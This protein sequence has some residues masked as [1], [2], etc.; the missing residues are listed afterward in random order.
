MKQILFG[1][2]FMASLT[3]A[4]GSGLDLSLYYGSR[5]VGLGG[6]QVALGGDAYGPFYNPATMTSVEK[7]ALAID[8][9]TLLFQYDAPIGAANAQK[10]SEW[11]VGPLFY[12]GGVYHLMDRVSVGLAVFP[13]A[14]QGGKYTPVDYGSGAI[15]TLSG[16]EMSNL[17]ARIEIAPSVA[18][19]VC[20]HFSL[21][22]SY[23]IAYTRYD[24]AGG[25]FASVVGTQA[26]FIDTSLTGWDATGAKFGAFVDHWNN[27]SAGITYRLETQ[28]DLSG[29]SDVT[30]G[31][32]PQTGLSAKS[33]PTLPAQFQAG[34]AYDF[35]PDQ[36]M[37]AF[38]YEFTQN[39]NI[40]SD[41]TEITGLGTATIPLKYRDGH[42]FHLGSEYSFHLQEKNKLKTS[43]GLAVDLASSVST[44]PNPLLAPGATYI[45]YA[46][47][48]QYEMQSQT[49]GVA[50]NY[51]NYSKR[52]T[53]DTSLA[54]Y[55]FAGKYG[56]EVWFFVADY[57]YKF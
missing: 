43:L 50:V 7:G 12:M 22:A 39:S 21:G 56:L 40:T 11:N 30:T 36:W 44:F 45:G 23:R 24:K 6:N 4:F 2:V 16:K 3:P 51:G 32:G 52:S 31:L 35:I 20:D 34:I 26:V 5:Y 15:A 27:L 19:K 17:L 42:G 57:Q 1:V 38:T 54:P 55:Y 29:S 47:G 53:P 49:V 13:T 9:S 25:A 41:T 48:V 37:A 28:P 8:S 33:S 18:F 14:L 10:K 46:G